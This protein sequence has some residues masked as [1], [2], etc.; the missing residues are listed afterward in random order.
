[1]LRA[2][3]AKKKGAPELGAGP[4]QRKCTFVTLTDLATTKRAASN[5]TLH[6]TLLLYLRSI[7]SVTVAAGSNVKNVNTNMAKLESDSE[8]LS[9]KFLL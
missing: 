3:Q 4:A 1:M 7:S 9:R 6:L 2:K 8:T 5:L